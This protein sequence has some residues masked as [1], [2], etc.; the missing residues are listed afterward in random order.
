MSE[1]RRRKMTAEE[2]L[3]ILRNIKDV[4]FATV[5]D[6]GMPH[7]RIIDVMLVEEEKLY[8][9]TARGK[10]LYRQLKNLPRT[11]IT[12]M[13]REYQMV[14]LFGKVKRLTDQ[15]Q[16]IDRI[17]RENPSMNDVY[18]GESRYSL[19]AWKKDRLSFLILER[20]PYTGRV[21]QPGRQRSRRK[22]L[23]LQTHVSGAGSVKG[24]V[25]SSALRKGFPL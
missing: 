12:G 19:S 23:R 1:K 15:K 6:K 2:C 11:E 4:A 5:D 18:P 9:C 7:V 14:R 16:W 22:D 10:D 13:N 3:Q 8:F 25:P 24:T 20:L 17:F 21:L